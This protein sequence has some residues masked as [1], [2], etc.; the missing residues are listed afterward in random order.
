M[1]TLQ[2]SLTTTSWEFLDTSGG[3]NKDQNPNY[4]CLI[5]CSDMN[6]QIKANLPQDFAISIGAQYEEALAQAMNSSSVVSELAGKARLA[7]VQ[8]VTQALTAQVW[9]GST[10]INFSLPLTL[11]VNNDE[12]TDVLKPLSDLYTLC[13]PDE[14]TSG[15]FLKAPGPTLSVELLKKSTGAFASGVMNVAKDSDTVKAVGNLVTDA[16]NIGQ[17]VVSGVTS[18]FKSNE[19]QL[20]TSE[21]K[22]AD[23]PG[24]SNV[25]DPTSE[26]Q[27]AS[28]SSAIK[29]NISLTIGQYM[30]FDSVVI[31]N[32]DQTHHVQPLENGTL[33]RVDVTVTFKTFFVPTRK[34]IGKIFLGLTKTTAPGLS[35]PR[36]RN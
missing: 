29:N 5:T 34:D 35:N 23:A 1:A 13:L 26:G 19:R 17:K 14:V 7:G 32:V 36:S 24:K 12:T 8:L 22:S 33:S 15:G 2:R 10:E 20:S 11:Q 9:Q 6:I 16:Q 31:T 30:H 21:S 18:L 3:D 25:Q 27:P 4:H 28:L